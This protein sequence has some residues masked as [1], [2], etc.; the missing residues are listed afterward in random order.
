[1]HHLCLKFKKNSGEGESPLPRPHPLLFRPP[2]IPKFWI[3]R[4]LQGP[5]I[6]HMY[7]SQV[8]WIELDADVGYLC[9]SIAAIFQLRQ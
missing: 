1:M 4:W 7:Y 6:L 5:T 2:P 8:R 9:S 3:R